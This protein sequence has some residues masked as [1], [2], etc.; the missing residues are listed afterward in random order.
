MNHYAQYLHC[1]GS[2]LIIDLRTFETEQRWGQIVSFDALPKDIILSYIMGRS[3]AKLTIR[4]LENGDCFFYLEFFLKETI[5]VELLTEDIRWVNNYEEK[6][7]Q[8]PYNTRYG[9][10]KT[11][12][13]HAYYDFSISGSLL[14]SKLYRYRLLRTE[15]ETGESRILELLSEEPSLS[16][17]GTNCLKITLNPTPEETCFAFLFSKGK[18]FST[19]KRLEEY[20]EYYFGELSHN[21]VW[22]SFFLLPS[23]TYTKLPYSIE[24]FTKDGYGFSLHHSS[25][26]DLFHLPIVPHKF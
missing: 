20:A 8:P 15:Y 10:T 24:P 7:R 14:A 3:V 23:G 1:E 11:T 26:K 19:K 21:C 12:G 4:P 18:L 6:Y 17:V 13:F 2:R 22:C 9:L 5:A 16:I 25:R